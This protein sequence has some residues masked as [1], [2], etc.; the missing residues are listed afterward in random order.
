MIAVGSDM[1]C[2]M[3]SC[4]GAQREGNGRLTLGSK[5]LTALTSR[6]EAWIMDKGRSASRERIA[7]LCVQW[8]RLARVTS[9]L[10]ILKERRANGT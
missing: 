6:T 7:R 10:T 8:Y 1:V 3:C 4:G 5:Q 9:L 2:R